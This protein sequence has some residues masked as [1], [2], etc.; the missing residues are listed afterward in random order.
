MQRAT[1]LGRNGRMSAWLMPGDGP[2]GL[3][4]SR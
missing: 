2:D 1:L 3:P 4:E